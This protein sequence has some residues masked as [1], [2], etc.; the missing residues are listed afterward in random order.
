MD[1]KA[2]GSSLTL[3]FVMPII[4]LRF[5]RIGTSLSGAKYTQ[6]DESGGRFTVKHVSGVSTPTVKLGHEQWYTVHVG[7]L[8]CSFSP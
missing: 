5:A 1:A 3:F 6:K 7:L 8:T 2:P 4:P